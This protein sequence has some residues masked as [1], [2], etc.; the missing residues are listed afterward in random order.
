[1][2]HLDHVFDYLVAIIG[3]LFAWVLKTFS[4]RMGKLESGLEKVRAENHEVALLV[5]GQYVTRQDMDKTL[6][7]IFRKLDQINEKLDSK[8]D[9]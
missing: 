5:A 8:Q 6:G 1:M 2:P 9:R 3:S 4:S 7:T